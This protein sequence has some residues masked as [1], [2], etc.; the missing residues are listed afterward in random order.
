[1]ATPIAAPGPSEPVAAAEAAP[2]A[3]S[4]AEGAEGGPD[5]AAGGEAA[6][7]TQ[8][9][10]AAPTADFG[11]PAPYPIRRLAAVYDLFYNGEAP[12]APV[13]RVTHVWSTDGERYVAESVAEG[14]GLVSLL[15]GGKFAQRSEGR[16]GAEGLVP[17][18][19]TLRR[20]GAAI[21]DE[22]RFDWEMATA[23]LASKGETRTVAIARGAQDPLS[24]LHQFYFIQPLAAS[25]RFSVADGR[26]LR[27]FWYEVV[28]EE[29]IETALGVVNAL[30]MRRADGDNASAEVWV[31]PRRSYLP[32][33]ILATDRK[34]R[35]IAQH[36]RSLEVE[37]VATAAVAGAGR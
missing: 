4:N 14:V 10:S 37:P 7:A 11:A 33:K 18:R 12:E 36:I 1:M 34:G 29:L 3:A 25:G 2:V 32:V 27:T 17:D 23:A 21:S 35:V 16:I 30:H 15:Y 31:D 8:A 20:G 22:A 9:R 19:Y 28:G 26:R 6:P 13:G 24:A 5:V